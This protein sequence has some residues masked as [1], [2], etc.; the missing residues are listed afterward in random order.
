MLWICMSLCC[1]EDLH[2]EEKGWNGT[3]LK[4]KAMW[5]F[6][7]KKRN[8][9]CRPACKYNTFCKRVT[10]MSFRKMAVQQA[11][12]FLMAHWF[13]DG[14]VQNKVRKMQIHHYKYGTDFFNYIATYYR[15]SLCCNVLGPIMLIKPQFY[16]DNHWLWFLTSSFTSLTKIGANCPYIPTMIKDIYLRYLHIYTK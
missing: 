16:M 8:V 5:L 4:S 12:C 3:L 2:N 9:E 7:R 11:M 14:Q 1:G 13:T 15:C 10:E 6:A